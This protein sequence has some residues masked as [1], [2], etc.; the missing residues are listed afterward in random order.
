MLIRNYG[1]YW[2]VDEVNWGKQGV[3]NDGTLEGVPAKKRSTKATNFR[4]QAG[5]YVLY[6]N[7]RP[8]YAGETGIGDQ[9]L[10]RRLRAHRRGTLKNRWNT[11]SWFGIYAVNPK[12]RM[13]RMNVGIHPEID[14][15]LY[16]IEA[17][18]IAAMEPPLNLQRGK[19]GEAEHFVQKERTSDTPSQTDMLEEIIKLLKTTR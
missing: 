9:R 1:L 3:G 18:L 10:F 14:D 6:D 12:S 17:V 4:E 2:N 8:V 7:L 15:V 11:F 16:H 5:V 13:L 19:F